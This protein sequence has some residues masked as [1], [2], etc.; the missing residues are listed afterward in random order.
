MTGRKKIIEVTFLY[1]SCISMSIIFL[2]ANR[3][4]MLKVSTYRLGWH[5]LHDVQRVWNSLELS[6]IFSK[7]IWTCWGAFQSCTWQQLLQIQILVMSGQ[8]VQLEIT[9]GVIGVMMTPSSPISSFFHHVTSH[10]HPLSLHL[11]IFPPYY[12]LSPPHLPPSP[13]TT[14]IILLSS[15]CLWIQFLALFIRLITLYHEILQDFKILN[16]SHTLFYVDNIDPLFQIFPL[17][18]IA[19]GYTLQHYNIFFCILLVPVCIFTQQMIYSLTCPYSKC[20]GD[21]ADSSL[22][23]FIF[24]LNDCVLQIKNSAHLFKCPFFHPYPCFI[25]IYLNNIL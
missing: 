22:W 15:V 17:S 19:S 23:H 12:L 24:I 10:H 11:S 8:V 1:V 13:E 25:P 9:V 20:I 14:L 2:L 16:L 4:N 18:T 21:G 6:S 3:E 7:W 5:W